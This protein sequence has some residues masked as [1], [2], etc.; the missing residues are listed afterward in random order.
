[1][2]IRL[3]NITKFYKST[4]ENYI[5]SLDGI[6]IDINYGSYISFVG[7]SGSGKTTLLNIITGNLKPSSGEVYWGKIA[8]T[9]A[10]DKKI[11]QIRREK[12]GIVFQDVKFIPE[13]TV[14]DNILLPLV[15]NYIPIA[16]KK[17]YF[18]NLI[19]SLKLGIIIKKLPSGLSGGEKKKVA[20][21][22]ALI[23][24]PE[25]LIADEPTA[26][27]DDNSAREIYHIFSNLNKLGLTIVVATH[28]ERF[29]IYCRETYFMKGGKIEGFKGK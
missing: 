12:F 8:L 7:P 24:N 14:M 21:A 22:R 9:K 15:I 5:K 1:M 28:D 18:D 26:N 25:I 29:G 4:Q 10:S 13:L 27:L 3:I 2:D 20:I 6:N 11:S 19:E 23:T 16:S 17:Q